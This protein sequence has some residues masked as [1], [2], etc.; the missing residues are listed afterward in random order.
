MCI[1]LL[2][3]KD[4]IPRLGVST[5]EK[6]VRVRERRQGTFFLGYGVLRHEGAYLVLGSCRFLARSRESGVWG[7]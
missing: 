1:S 7:S 6:L 4:M 3:A 5:A 2:Y